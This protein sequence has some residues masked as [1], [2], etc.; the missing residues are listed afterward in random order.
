ME[1][2]QPMMYL[3]NREPTF[4]RPLRAASTT[5]RLVV[6]TCL[7]SL[8][9][10]ASPVH[11][12]CV[13]EGSRQICSG[14]TTTSRNLELSSRA[15]QPDLVVEA[16]GSY[17][18]TNSNTVFPNGYGLRLSVLP[19]HGR[20]EFT[21]QAGGRISG[22]DMGLHVSN[23]GSGDSAL[24]LSG[25]VVGVRGWAA[26]VVGSRTTAAMR[27]AQP[28]GAIGGAAG[29][30]AVT[31]SGR[32]NL[33]VVSGGRI[34]SGTASA[35]LLNSGSTTDNLRVQQSGGSVF[36]SDSPVA[37]VLKTTHDGLGDLNLDLDGTIHSSGSGARAVAAMNTG[38][39]GVLSLRQGASGD[40]SSGSDA[41]VLLS[42]GQEGAQVNLSGRIASARGQGVY[43]DKRAGAG[44]VNLR[45]AGQITGAT[46]GITIINDAGVPGS[47]DPTRILLEGDVTGSSRAGV[48]VNHSTAGDLILRQMQG[49]VAGGIDGIHLLNTGSGEAQI[50]LHGDVQ[51]NRY[52]AILTQ[53][54]NGNV[55]VEQ[56]SGTLSGGELGLHINNPGEGD[57]SVSTAAD[58]RGGRYG[59][60]LTNSGTSGTTH[61]NLH[62][63]S[64]TF[65]GGEA[66]LV[67]A[68]AGKFGMTRLRLEGNTMGGSDAAIVANTL[69]TAIEIMAD[70]RVDGR[71]SGTAIRRQEMINPHDGA[72]VRGPLHVS[73]SGWMAGDA[74]LGYG[75]DVFKLQGGHLL[76]SI[77]ADHAP[78]ATRVAG[79]FAGGDDTFE[80]SAGEFTGNFYG[81]AGSDS[82]RI[83]AT[84]YDGSQQFD[85]GD[86]TSA[87]DGMIDR[88]TL[89]GVS[90]ATPGSHLRN[91]EV[92]TLRGAQLQI[93]DGSW[94]VGMPDEQATG[95]WLEDGASLGGASDLVLGANL[96]I[97]ATSRFMTQGSG[98]GRHVVEGNV[99][100]AG[101]ITSADG[102]AGDRLR[103]NGNYVGHDAH[104]ALDT[105]LAGD[106]AATDQFHVAGNAS[107]TTRVNIHN[108]GGMGAS[109]VR[110][111]PVITVDGHSSEDAFALDG[112][113][114]AGAYDYFLRKGQGNDGNWYLKSEL[115]DA[116]P[117]VSVG[118]PSGQVRPE[119][120]AYKANLSLALDMFRLGFHR[121]HAGQHAGRAWARVD[122]SQQRFNA[123]Q[124]LHIRS[125]AHTASAGAEL[126]RRPSGSSAGIEVSRGRA[127]STSVSDLT[128]YHAR[129][130]VKGTAV[131]IHGTWRRAGNSEDY[132]GVYVDGSLQYARF[133][134]RVDGVALQ[135]ERYR[136][137]SVKA[138][139]EIGYAVRVGSGSRG[140]HL[141]PQLQLGYSN[142][143][144]RRHTE[145]NGTQ[146][147]GGDTVGLFG[148]MG[149]RVSGVV[150]QAGTAA[151]V[152]PF[153]SADWVHGAPGEVSMDGDRIDAGS[154]RNRREFSAGA[155]IGFANGASAWMLISLQEANGRNEAAAQVGISYR[156]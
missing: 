111:I 53:E 76:G 91:W 68:N 92:V 156:W 9:V 17:L 78:G 72:A 127:S 106:D 42:Y 22:G 114:V 51:A 141:E 3:Q 46:S 20:L 148:R 26:Q 28:E 49:A 77:H 15:A 59:V 5:A 4:G 151:R 132:A 37:D 95:V 33:D 21:Q 7:S 80:W 112:R 89:V 29:G 152:Q 108:T 8:M 120:G 93:N 27:I 135:P 74:I 43:L 54:G 117:E 119:A 55:R 121:R 41:V 62:Q 25:S 73:S 70:A 145:T 124:Q 150:K 69:S 40:I 142:L 30:L 122:N 18:R 133:Q 82:V 105:V 16:D 154:S 126:W 63:T 129:G 47:L 118:W 57:V 116:Q 94:V 136:S 1:Q 99:A 131:A 87:T 144:G 138:A 45:A 130:E 146:V 61:I 86:D 67:I 110:G 10:L 113:V 102:K 83:S 155:T 19:G 6:P 128:G 65:S 100:S 13:L 35:L 96:H 32:G 143:R 81:Q 75:D 58:I 56:Y 24:S 34:T 44:E 139:A 52:G 12:A 107:G 115:P 11:A 71:A 104:L 64:G 140:V 98:Q 36:H 88:L 123:A 97:D 149:L 101:V 134:N 14:T 48:L 103:I 23:T 39:G 31:H 85:G 109:T 2:L 153:I 137:S 147:E 84:G 50:E 125:G 79:E 38:S 60:S 90:T 66:G